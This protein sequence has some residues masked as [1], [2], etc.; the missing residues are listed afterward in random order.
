MNWPEVF[1]SSTSAVYACGA[2]TEQLQRDQR[3][4][5]R[6]QSAVDLLVE[7]ALLLVVVEPQARQEAQAIGQREFATWPKS[8]ALDV[9]GTRGTG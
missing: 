3:R 6:L 8:A 1:V 2:R 5:G 4:V 7:I 9:A